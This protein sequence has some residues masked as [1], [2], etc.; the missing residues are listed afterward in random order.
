MQRCGVKLNTEYFGIYDS[1]AATYTGRNTIS[2][3]YERQKK[4]GRTYCNIRGDKQLCTV[5]I[6]LSLYS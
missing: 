3:A 4:K 2:P 5:N 6:S 1:N